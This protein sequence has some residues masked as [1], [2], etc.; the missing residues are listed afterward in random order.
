MFFFTA[1]WGEKTSLADDLTMVGLECIADSGY[2]DGKGH[3]IPY[4]YFNNAKDVE[5]EQD[6]VF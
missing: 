6:D 2:L 3:I 5:D 1:L 4:Y